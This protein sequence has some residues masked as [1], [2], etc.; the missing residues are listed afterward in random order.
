MIEIIGTIFKIVLLGYS[1]QATIMCR[2]SS[3][4]KSQGQSELLTYFQICIPSYVIGETVIVIALREWNMQ[5]AQGNTNGEMT[6]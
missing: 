6:A 1:L 5:V 3:C 2:V 4:T